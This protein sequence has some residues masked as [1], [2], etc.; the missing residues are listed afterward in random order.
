MRVRTRCSKMRCFGSRLR[1]ERVR[2]DARGIVFNGK[3]YHGSAWTAGEI[4]TIFLALQVGGTSNCRPKKL[5]PAQA[6]PTGRMDQSPFKSAVNPEQSDATFARMARR[7]S[8]TS[9]E[10]ICL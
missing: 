10:P 3:V 1:T 2:A 4:G 8:S 7:S 5:I 9:T 6:A